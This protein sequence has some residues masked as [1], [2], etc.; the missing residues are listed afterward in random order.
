[1]FCSGIRAR[2][3]PCVSSLHN[4]RLPFFCAL[5]I[6]P[7]LATCPTHLI[8]LDLI[9]LKILRIQYKLC[10]YLIYL[11]HAKPLYFPIYP[12]IYFTQTVPR[13]KS[14]L[15]YLNIR[16]RF[17]N[18]TLHSW[19]QTGASLSVPQ[20]TS[21]LRRQTQGCSCMLPLIISLTRICSLWKDP[22]LR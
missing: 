1:M 6:L 4:F 2:V 18:A 21:G 7:I 15:L 10:I 3:T 12:F 13:F 19:P 20:L 9:T 16:S 17:C 11:Q 8:L 5:L 22:K 14:Q